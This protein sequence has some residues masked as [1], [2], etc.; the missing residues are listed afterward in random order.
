VITSISYDHT[1]LL[2]ETLAEIAAEKGGIIK[3]GVPVVLSPQKDEA[4]LVI[5]R[6]AAQCQAPL[7]QVGRDYLFAPDSRSLED[8]TLLVWQ[9]SDQERL[10]AFIESGGGDEWEPVRLTIPLLGYH[11]VENAATAYAAVQ[12]ARKAGF[13]VAETAIRQGF[14]EVYWPACLEI[15]SVIRR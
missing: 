9:A 10:D 7:T 1:Y 13:V 8:Q 3:P 14:S 4:R 6:I 2:G 11:Q 5:E 12:V 15:Y